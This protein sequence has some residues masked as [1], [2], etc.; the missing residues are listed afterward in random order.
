MN[1][2]GCQNLSNLSSIRAYYFEASFVVVHEILAYK[3]E[4]IDNLYNQKINLYE[5][6]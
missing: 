6:Q 3:F 2:M 1:R 4:P 5:N